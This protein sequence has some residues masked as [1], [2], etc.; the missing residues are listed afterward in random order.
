M[1]FESLPE[2]AESKDD[3]DP[4]LV[5]APSAAEDAAPQRRGVLGG[6]GGAVPPLAT[7][8]LSRA[9]SASIPQPCPILQIASVAAP[10]PGADS[11]HARLALYCYDRL[12]CGSA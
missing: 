10:K 11:R 7:L 12:V 5:G 3:A 8:L 6:Q 1:L 2:N 4:A 9:G